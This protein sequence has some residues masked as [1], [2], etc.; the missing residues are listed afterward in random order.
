MGG[1]D[2][3]SYLS[4]APFVHAA[5]AVGLQW[6]VGSGAACGVHLWRVGGCAPVGEAS[7]AVGRLHEDARLIEMC[8][9]AWRG[10]GHQ[11]AAVCGTAWDVWGCL[12]GFSPRSARCPLATAPHVMAVEQG[13]PCHP[14]AAE[15]GDQAHSL[16]AASRQAAASGVRCCGASSA[17]STRDCHWQWVLRARLLDGLRWMHGVARCLQ[18]SG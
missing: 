6:D 3:C 1:V 4:G 9:A 10:V 14:V 16:Y 7:G 17:G 11:W 8:R 2:G 15:W 18:S 5:W 12:R 13:L